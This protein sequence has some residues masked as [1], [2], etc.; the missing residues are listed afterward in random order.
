MLRNPSNSDDSVSPPNIVFIRKFDFE[1]GGTVPKD[2]FMVV[3]LQTSSDA[4]IAPLTT[5][6]DYIPD[7]QKGPR[8][9]IDDP[10]RL[11]CYCIPKELAIGKKGFFFPKD[12]YIQVQGNLMKRSISDL[13]NKYLINGTASLLDEL[14]DAEYCDLLCCI[15]MSQFVPRGIRKEIKPVIAKLQG[16]A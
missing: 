10:S 1:K 14:T 8:C 12:T 4:I 13:T 5:S 11:H 3:L 2:K 15:C 6:K 7:N 9:V 16:R